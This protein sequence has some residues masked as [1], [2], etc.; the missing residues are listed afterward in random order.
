MNASRTS[1]R[2]APPHPA[3]RRAE[4]GMLIGG[5]VAFVWAGAMLYT[6]ASWIF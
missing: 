2:T 4:A 1:T 6:L 3:R 5:A